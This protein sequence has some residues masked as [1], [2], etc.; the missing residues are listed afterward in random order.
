MLEIPNLISLQE[1]ALESC[2]SLSVLCLSQNWP[3]AY[4]CC[5]SD[6]EVRYITD[7][8]YLMMLKFSQDIILQ[9]INFEHDRDLS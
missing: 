2:L 5:F 3:P 8:N 9:I 7:F 4:F 6:A 1:N